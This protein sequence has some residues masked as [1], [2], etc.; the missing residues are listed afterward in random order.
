MQ[1]LTLPLLLLLL[2]LILALLHI[3]SL[4]PSVLDPW[5]FR[6]VTDAVWRTVA[7]GDL[8]LDVVEGAVCESSVMAL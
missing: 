7:S 3:S 5:S 8:F 1:V 6:H 2:L 4:L